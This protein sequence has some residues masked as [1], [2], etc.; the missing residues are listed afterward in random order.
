MNWNEANTACALSGGRLPIIE[1][2]KSFWDAHGTTPPNMQPGGYWSS[3]TYAD[4]SGS[5]W[6]VYMGIGY[7]EDA[8]K[9]GGY[10]SARC[11][12]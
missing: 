12:R 6:V 10:G 9:G 3:T 8:D 4:W 11:V 5:A 7:V 2:L 1:E